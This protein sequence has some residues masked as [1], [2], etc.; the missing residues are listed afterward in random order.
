MKE[1]TKKEIRRLI[2]L[3]VITKSDD[4]K[5]ETC[6]ADRFPEEY[7]NESEYIS[8]QEEIGEL[9]DELIEQKIIKGE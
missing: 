9:V 3:N 5:I 6:I 8:F 7:E 4:E 2:V 1:E